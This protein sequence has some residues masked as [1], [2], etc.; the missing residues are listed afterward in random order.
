VPGL[1]GNSLYYSVW[2]ESKEGMKGGFKKK[3][4]KVLT[5][6]LENAKKNLQDSLYSVLVDSLKNKIP[7]GYILENK[8]ISKE[9]Q[10]IS[11]LAKPE[12]HVSEFNCK[13]KMKVKG[14]A[15]SSEDLKKL[16]ISLISNKI[17]SDEDIYQKS[18]E[19]KSLPL[20]LFPEEGKMILDLEIQGEIYKKVPRELILSKIIGNSKEEIK[21]IVFENYPQTKI[22]KIK[23]WPFWVKKAPEKV[24]RI[25][26]KLTF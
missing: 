8:A 21:K 19:L 17:S 16:S 7:E 22:L 12:D 25:K 4:K 15:F 1:S 20:S 13:A 6:D 3:V 23:F 2:A 26:L 10:E 24:E 14:F 11:C 5:K 9:S 18:L